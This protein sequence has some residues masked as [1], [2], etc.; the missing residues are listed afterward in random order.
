MTK[1]GRS[2]ITSRSFYHVEMQSIENAI[3]AESNAEVPD[4][5]NTDEDL[6]VEFVMMDWGCHFLCAQIKCIIVYLSVV[7]IGETL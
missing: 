6:C 4:K 3:I 2:G 5:N 7:E 1:E